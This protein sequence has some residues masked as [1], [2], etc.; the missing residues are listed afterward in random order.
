MPAVQRD[1]AA[2][3]TR[4]RQPGPLFYHRYW[5]VSLHLLYMVKVAH[6][7]VLFMFDYNWSRKTKRVYRNIRSWCNERL[8]ARAQLLRVDLTTAVPGDNLF[9]KRHFQELR[10]RVEHR[11]GYVIDYFKIETSEGNGVYHMI[12]AIVHKTPVYISQKW[13]SDQWADIHKSPIVYIKRMKTFKASI[14]RVANYLVAQYLAGQ[15]AIV[16]VSYSWWRAKVAIVRGWNTLYREYRKRCDVN[17]WVGRNQA[18]F[19]LNFADL[20][21]AW[22][23]LLLTGRCSLG[24][25]SYYVLNRDVVPCDDSC[26]D[27][28]IDY[29]VPSGRGGGRPMSER[30]LKYLIWLNHDRDYFLGWC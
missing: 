29:Y 14:G 16:R 20:I 15:S 7:L 5:K 26:S 24:G 22:E 3:V 10:R 19:T 4:S 9:L 21:N 6:F 23:T 8:A 11:Y 1:P 27:A 17:T 12:W 30:R 25:K 28:P 18:C 2:Q 13:L